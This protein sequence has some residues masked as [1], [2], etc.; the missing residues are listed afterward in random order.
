MHIDIRRFHNVQIPKPLM[1]G[2]LPCQAAFAVHKGQPVIAGPTVYG[3]HSIRAYTV[4]E[5]NIP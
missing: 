5:P 4:I 3:I 2:H 1:T